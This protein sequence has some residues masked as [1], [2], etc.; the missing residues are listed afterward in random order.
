MIMKAD[1]Y[2]LDTFPFSALGSWDQEP[3]RRGNQG[4]RRQYDYLHNLSAFDIE[5]TR[6]PE[7]EQAWMY[8]WMWGFEDIGVLIGRSWEELRQALELVKAQ[9]GD[10]TL[11]IL[12]HCPWSSRLFPCPG[13]CR[14][15]C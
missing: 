6:D 3:R 13:Y 2:T 15:C 4:T 11:V 10:N 1:R 12:V 9:I 14:Q 8:I 5:T 7:S